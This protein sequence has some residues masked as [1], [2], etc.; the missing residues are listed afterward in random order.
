[1]CPFHGAAGVFIA[2]IRWTGLSE[3][4]CSY[5]LFLL[6]LICFA[7]MVTQLLSACC[8]IPSC[9]WWCHC[10]NSSILV[11]TVSFCFLAG[12][13]EGAVIPSIPWGLPAP[14]RVCLHCCY[15]ALPFCFHHHLHSAPQVG[16][17]HPLSLES[18]FPSRWGAVEMHMV[19]FSSQHQ[20]SSVPDNIS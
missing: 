13:E 1:M 11:L 18:N 6:A 15:A 3:C 7:V 12:S 5:V 9:P 14:G 19:L 8:P 20:S 4:H 17:F 10:Q 2:V 16:Q